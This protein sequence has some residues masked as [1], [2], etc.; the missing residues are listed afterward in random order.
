MLSVHHKLEPLHTDKPKEVARH[1]EY[2]EELPTENGSL[3]TLSGNVPRDA[4]QQ[5]L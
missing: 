5:H 2:P 3:S 4:I 1:R